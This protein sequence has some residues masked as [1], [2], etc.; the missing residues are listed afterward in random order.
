MIA[1][2]HLAIHLKIV[3][4]FKRQFLLKMEI[5]FRQMNSQ[6]QEGLILRNQADFYTLKITR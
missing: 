3:L 1:F 4:Y 6:E 5:S 2:V